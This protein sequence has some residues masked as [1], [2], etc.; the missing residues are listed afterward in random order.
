M[1]TFSLVV[2][3][4]AFIAACSQVPKVVFQSAFDGAPD[5]CEQPFSEGRWQLHHLIEAKVHGRSMGQL[6]GVSVISAADRTIECALMTIEGLVLFSARY[7]GKLTVM[8]AVAPFDRPGFAR[9]LVDD[10]MLLFFKPTAPLQSRGLLPG[11]EAV[12]RYGAGDGAVVDTV[13][14]DR[15]HWAVYRYSTGGRLERTIEGESAAAAFF[16][17]AH[18]TIKSHGRM[19]YVLKLK[20]LEAL[21]LAEN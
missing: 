2:A 13:F 19:E 16:P 7:D 8:R 11:G 10:L 12:C 15:R 4:S 18:L 9:G 3:L 21:P 17:A 5:Y 14:K 6:T 20:L 1:R